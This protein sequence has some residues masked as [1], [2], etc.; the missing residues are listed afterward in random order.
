MPERA[1]R[2]FLEMDNIVAPP[3]RTEFEQYWAPSEFKDSALPTEKI[4]ML[5]LQLPMGKRMMMEREARGIADPSEFKMSEYEKYWAPSTF[6]KSALTTTSAYEA[7]LKM[8]FG[9][10]CM[11]EREARGFVDADVARSEFME[12]WTPRQY[13]ASAITKKSTFEASLKMPFGKR[14]VLEREARGYCE[15]DMSPETKVTS[16]YLA[17]W[18]PVT[19]TKSAL[20]PDKFAASLS[21]PD[22]ARTMLEREARGVKMIA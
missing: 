12:F 16:E 8:P 14:M 20:K 2:G 10:R 19:A 17:Y 7:S 9:K 1:A 18:A 21:M 11:I 22:G 6:K 4:F 15:V 13:E 5:S 3:A